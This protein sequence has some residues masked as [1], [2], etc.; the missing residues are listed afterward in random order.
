MKQILPILRVLIKVSAMV[1]IGSSISSPVAASC[2]RTLVVPIMPSGLAVVVKGTNFNGIVPEFLEQVSHKSGCKFSYHL[3]PKSRQENLFE[4]AQADLLLTAV[5][6]AR[7]DQFGVFVPL[8]QL[9][10]VLISTEHHQ[11]PMQSLK[12]L[13]ASAST[14]LVI[15]R[16]F[17]YGLAYQ[18]IVEDM[19]REGRLLV[20]TDVISVIRTLKANVTYA[21]IMAPTIFAGT[22]QTEP[23]LNDLVGK[24]RYEKLDELPWTESGIYISTL[25]LHD[26]DRNLLKLTM[27]KMAQSE[28]IWKAYQQYYSPEVIKLGLRPREQIH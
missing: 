1:S 7:R 23:K 13:T 26:E 3:V 15:V 19:K 4:N 11:P 10:A 21:T 22:L 28:A 17:D 18:T 16:G 2:S 27:D 8:V 5:R 14:K 9:R 12:E 25:T 20:E 24:V 6:T